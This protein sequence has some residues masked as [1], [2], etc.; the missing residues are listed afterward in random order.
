MTV[1]ALAQAIGDATDQRKRVSEQT[2]INWLKNSPPLLLLC[3]TSHLDLS[4]K[5]QGVFKSL[6]AFQ[7][8]YGV[9]GHQ[10]V[11]TSNVGQD[12]ETAQQLQGPF[13]FYNVGNPTWSR[14][15]IIEYPNAYDEYLASVEAELK[16]NLGSDSLSPRRTTRKSARITPSDAA[17]ILHRLW[18]AVEGDFQDDLRRGDSPIGTPLLMFAAT[19]LPPSCSEQINNELDLLKFWRSRFVPGLASDAP[20]AQSTL[21]MLNSILG[22]TDESS[23]LNLSRKNQTSQPLTGAIATEPTPPSQ[24]V[25]PATE[26]VDAP[27]IRPIVARPPVKKQTSPLIRA[28]AVICMLLPAAIAM[29]DSPWRARPATP[30]RE[31]TPQTSPSPPPSLESPPRFET[32]PTVP[33]PNGIKPPQPVISLPR[34]PQISLAFH[35]GSPFGDLDSPDS[36]QDQLSKPYEYLQPA[37]LLIEQGLAYEGAGAKVLAGIEH[38]GTQLWYCESSISQSKLPRQ[39]ECRFTD[40]AKHDFAQNQRW[41]LLLAVHPTKRE[42]R[43]VKGEFQSKAGEGKSATEYVVGFDTLTLRDWLLALNDDNVRLALWLFYQDPQ[44]DI[45]RLH[46]CET[47]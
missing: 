1:R 6:A 19:Q 3:D 18:P 36:Q 42:W 8:T 47:P 20:P 29:V 30:P 5:R 15:D 16:R 10:C 32:A 13:I 7:D 17:T 46:L 26:T 38:T 2:L 37:K 24:Q 27:F 28:L 25:S 23:T 4:P 44:P 31:R 21:F 22:A 14:S 39:L 40:Y 45:E 9:C 41:L 35:R 33:S 12:N 11:V 34:T 43:L